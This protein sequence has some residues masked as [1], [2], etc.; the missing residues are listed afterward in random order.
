[1][2]PDAD[3]VGFRLGVHYADFLG[4]RGFSH[5]L[6]F[7]AILAL[8]L[9]VLPTAGAHRRALWMYLFLA[10]ASHGLLDALT[11][12]GLGVALFAPFD[13]SRYFFPARPIAVSPIGLSHF[14]SA[15]GM[16]VIASEAVWVWLPSVLLAMAGLAFRKSR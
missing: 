14:F 8:S 3:V 4:H 13:N 1:M 7:A 11:D 5:S 12:G 16:S 6:V 10:T 15:G 9:V 2:L